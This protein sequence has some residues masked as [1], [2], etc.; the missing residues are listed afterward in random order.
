MTDNPLGFATGNVSY[1]RVLED[2]D[3][4]LISNCINDQQFNKFLV[5]GWKPVT[6]ENIQ[7]QFADERN[8]E[9]AI[10]FA[11]CEKNSDKFVGWCGLYKWDKISHSQELRSFVDPTNWGHGFG[12]EQHAFMLKIGFERYN[13]NRIHCGTNQNNS[14]VL[15]I[16]EKLDLVKEGISRQETFRNGKYFDTVRYSILRSEYNSKVKKLVDSVL[17]M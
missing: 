9:N 11:Q 2:D 16:Y 10:Q 14:G 1:L 3:Y 13:L 5:Q 15:R 8:I 4:E 7:K 17:S 6:P 12:T